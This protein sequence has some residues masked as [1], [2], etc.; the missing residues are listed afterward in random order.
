MLEC[1]ECYC[2]IDA[3]DQP[4]ICPCPDEKDEGFVDELEEQSPST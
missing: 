2:N 4:H 1:T 3:I